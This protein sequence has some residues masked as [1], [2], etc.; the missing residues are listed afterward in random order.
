MS[1]YDFLQAVKM[2]RNFEHLLFLL[3]LG[4]LKLANLL[5]EQPAQI[6]FLPA[7]QAP[8]SSSSGWPKSIKR[9]TFCLTAGIHIGYEIS[10][11]SCFLMPMSVNFKIMQFVKA[12][13]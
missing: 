3:A 4:F 9:L 13:P 7:I 12:V 1:I 8:F 6:L 10:T 5:K 2:E 11:L